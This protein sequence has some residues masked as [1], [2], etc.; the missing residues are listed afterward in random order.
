M[1]RLAYLYHPLFEK[2]DPGRGHPERPERLTAINAYLQRKGFW[3]RISRLE[4][5]PIDR[6]LLQLNHS[7]DYI[8]FILSQ[9]GKEGIVLDGGD[10]VLNAYSV[11]AALLAAG[12]GQ[13][14]VDAVFR[15][16]F[17]KVFAALR[18]P[19]HHAE[20]DKAMGFC[21][22]NNIAIAAR[23]ALL[24]NYVRKILI[25]DWDVHH[26]NGTQNAFYEDERVFYL[27]LHQY[28]LFPMTGLKTETGRGTGLGFT[29]NIPLPYGQGDAQYVQLLADAL[30]EIAQKFQP[31]L[32]LISAGFDAHQ[33]D[34]LGGMQVTTAGFYKM[35]ELVAQ[36]AHR[37]AQGR[38][39]S[40]LE[41]GY[42]L[43]SLA[44]SVY[45]HLLC[46]LKH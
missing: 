23:Y 26:G 13:A 39:I 35:T 38:V 36:F 45:R 43:Q 14:A 21:V 19:G 2:H 27:S 37:Y 6:H 40:F 16:N 44:E 17:D 3:P 24:Q 29:K 31:E 20:Y 12:A 30:Q 10:T 9:E 5:E 15:K 33:N 18:P 22:F 4:P 34:P 1:G 46:L 28:P 41:G 25:I 11:Q 32:V 8:D 42:H 7:S